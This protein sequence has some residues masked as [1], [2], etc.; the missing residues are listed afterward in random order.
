M[1]NKQINQLLREFDRNRREWIDVLKDNPGHST[2]AQQVIHI[3]AKMELLRTLWNW[4]DESME[5]AVSR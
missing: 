3:N 1:N 4:S 2:A 5:M